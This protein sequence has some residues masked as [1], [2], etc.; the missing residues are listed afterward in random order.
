MKEQIKDFSEELVSYVF[1]PDRL[2]RI[3]KQYNCDFI[4]LLSMY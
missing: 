4:T 1:N 2:E 3:A